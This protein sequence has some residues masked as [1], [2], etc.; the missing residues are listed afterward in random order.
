[1]FFKSS[2]SEFTR[3]SPIPSFTLQSAR[4]SSV[5]ISLI[6]YT[7]SAASALNRSPVT[8]LIPR[9]AVRGSSLRWR[10]RKAFL[11]SSTK[12]KKKEIPLPRDEDER[13]ISRH[14]TSGASPGEKSVPLIGRSE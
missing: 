10:R 1:M 11:F 2:P 14:L 12:K 5:F 13:R 4:Y 8:T 7:F 9:Q 3:Y 6:V